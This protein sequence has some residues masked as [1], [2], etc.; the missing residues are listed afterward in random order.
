M[1]A[2]VSGKLENTQAVPGFAPG[3][4]LPGS[5]WFC[6]PPL[7][8]LTEAGR[9]LKPSVLVVRRNTR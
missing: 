4:S 1:A 3:F 6:A 7:S 5:P 8:A 9:C 2:L